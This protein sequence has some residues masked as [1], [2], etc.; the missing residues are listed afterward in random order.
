M[1]KQAYIQPTME[2]VIIKSEMPLL[3]GS[4]L[5][6]TDTPLNND[7]ALS[8]GFGAPDLPPGIDTGLPSF[9]FE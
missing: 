5:N 6:M 3:T 2:V 1:K 7:N 4:V 9:I 8:P